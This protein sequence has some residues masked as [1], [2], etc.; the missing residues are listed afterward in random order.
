MA[1]A[2]ELPVAC[3]ASLSESGIP[4][5]EDLVEDQD[6]ADGAKR[7]RVGEPGAHAA[8]VVPQFQVRETLEAGEREDLARAPPATP[9]RKAP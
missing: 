8:R 3:L 4:D 6:F 1:C 2:V 5:G 9:S 7:H